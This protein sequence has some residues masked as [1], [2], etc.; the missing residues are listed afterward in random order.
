MSSPSAAPS[1]QSLPTKLDA[2]AP[3]QILLD[4]RVTAF[5]DGEDEAAVDPRP[6]IVLL[7]RKLGESGVVVELGERSARRRQ[8][9]LLGTHCFSQPR[10]DLEFDGECAVGG[11]DDA[12]LELGEL[13]CGEAHRIGERLAVD[14]ELGMRR[15]GQRRTMQSRHLDEIAEH[16]VVA[17]FQRFDAGPVGVCA[18]A[19]R[20]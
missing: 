4:H 2:F 10:E 14:E 5:L 13:G 3:P 17:H 1:V 15:L 12:R 6:H 11:L 8:R 16:V 18:P 20:R 19:G 7:D 9:L